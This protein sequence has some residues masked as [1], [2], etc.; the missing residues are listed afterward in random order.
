MMGRVQEELPS[1]F[2]LAHDRSDSARLQLAGKLSDLFLDHE[3]ELTPREEQMVNELIDLLLKTEDDSMRHELVKKFANA[4][5]PRRLA[6]N[7]AC[8][9]ALIDVAR[10]VLKTC[11]TLTDDDLITV[12]GIQSVDHACAVAERNHVSEA[13][14]DALVTTGSLLVMQTVAEN[15][16]AKLSPKA[17]T[18][19]AETARLVTSLQEPVMHR[20][21]LTPDAASRLYWWIA[22]DLRRN[23]LERFGFSAGLLD[24]ALARSIEQKLHEHIFERHDDEAMM[25]VADWLFERGAITLDLLPKLLRLN[26]FRLFNIALGRLADLDLALADIIVGEADGR[27]LAALC[28]ALCVDKAGFVSLFLLSRGARQD[29]HVVHPRELTKALTAF[30]RLSLTVA[31]DMLR[32]WR[33]NPAYLLERQ[34]ELAAEG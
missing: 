6:M 16:G 20:P 18:I 19:L 10:S 27:L 1:L 17:V 26:H 3:T 29:E 34:K 11:E 33:Q 24:L 30:D 28:R 32:T 25:R 13:V 7:L 8:G 5:L 21:E 23:I 22:Q 4:R 15:L 2:A 31:Q 14:A 9:S 12:V